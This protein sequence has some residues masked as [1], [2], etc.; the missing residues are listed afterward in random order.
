MAQGGSATATVM[1]DEE[2]T[3]GSHK[4]FPA[5]TSTSVCSDKTDTR[6]SM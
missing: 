2:L 4:H 5:S 6:P 1:D 3:C